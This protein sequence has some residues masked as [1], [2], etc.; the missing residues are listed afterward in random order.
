MPHEKSFQYALSF[1][2]YNFMFFCVND[3][4]LNPDTSKTAFPVMLMYRLV[5]VALEVKQEVIE[6]VLWGYD[7]FLNQHQLCK[8][9]VK[10]CSAK[11]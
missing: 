4:F 3:D 9:V 10:S 5:F 1:K 11:K 7:F 6:I 2:Q 8:I